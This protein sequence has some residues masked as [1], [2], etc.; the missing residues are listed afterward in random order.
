MIKMSLV[1][2]PRYLTMTGNLKGLTHPECGPSGQDHSNGSSS[3]PSGSEVKSASKFQRIQ[4]VSES[5]SSLEGN[6]PDSRST[7]EDA[8]MAF[9]G[10]GSGWESHNDQRSGG[11]CKDDTR[12][13]GR[14]GV[15]SMF[16]GNSACKRS[17]DAGETRRAASSTD[18][19]DA[20]LRVSRR[21][22]I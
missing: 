20:H 13:S 11:A 15:P 17:Y 18:P 21:L 22:R 7:L 14:N 3:S 1:A 9:T 4:N 2:T 8:G 6:M 10:Y 12:S 19:D 16:E 5:R